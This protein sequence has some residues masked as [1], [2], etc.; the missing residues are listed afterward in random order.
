MG[1]VGY[2]VSKNLIFRSGIE[3]GGGLVKNEDGG[4][5]EKSPGE[6]NFLPLAAGEFFTMEKVFAQHSFIFFREVFNELGGAGKAGGLADAAYIVN[7]SDVTKANVFA[8]GHVIGAKILE[9]D[10]DVLPQVCKVDFA[11]VD[12]INEDLSGGDV[13]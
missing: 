9:D 2:E 13:I 10:A 12:T 4:V 5:F 6:G 7:V 1:S 8:H 11:D 3:G